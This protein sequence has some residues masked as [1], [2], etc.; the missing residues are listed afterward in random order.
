MVKKYQD[1]KLVKKSLIDDFIY[2]IELLIKNNDSNQVIAQFLTT[3]IKDYEIEL[4]DTIF[5]KVYGIFQYKNLNVLN[6]PV[7]YANHVDTICGL[8]NCIK[9]RVDIETLAMLIRDRLECLF[10]LETSQV[11]PNCKTSGLIIVK[12]KK[13]LYECRTCT[14]LQDL[15]GYKYTTTDILTIPT[16]TDLKKIEQ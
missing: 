9:F 14:F 16:M 11:C 7:S 1:Y 4:V 8:K 2:H 5:D 6:Y 12:E 13:L 15:N 3:W 10:F